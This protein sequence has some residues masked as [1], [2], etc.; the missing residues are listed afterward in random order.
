MSENGNQP[1][2]SEYKDYMITVML[3]QDTERFYAEYD[4]GFNHAGAALGLY[5]TVDD[6]VAACQHVIDHP[7]EG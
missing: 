1:H 7:Y 4:D 6:A 3:W 5:D 2:I